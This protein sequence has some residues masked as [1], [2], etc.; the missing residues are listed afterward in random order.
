MFNMYELQTPSE[1]KHEFSIHCRLSPDIYP[2]SWKSSPEVSRHGFLPMEQKSMA[3]A[4]LSKKSWSLRFSTSKRWVF[5]EI[6]VFPRKSSILIGFSIINHPF[7]DTPIFG[8]TQMVGLEKGFD[9]PWCPGIFDFLGEHDPKVP[10]ISPN[11]DPNFSPQ[12]FIKQKPVCL[13][14]SGLSS[15]NLVLDTS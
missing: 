2:R 13:C 5:P 8:N 3:S 7:W 1:K 6:G 4:E 12:G 9:F 11:K 10:T 14:S 15:M